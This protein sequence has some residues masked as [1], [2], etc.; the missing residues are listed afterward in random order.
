MKL[1]LRFHLLLDMRT[2][3][4]INSSARTARSHTR[5][6][7]N[8]FV[9]EW[10]CLRPEDLV[11]SREIGTEPPS[12]VSE[13]WIASAFTPPQDRTP[14]MREALR[15]SDTLVDELV[16][17]DLIVLGAPMYNFGMPAQLKA[18]VDQ[19]IRVG[20]TFALDVSDEKQ[21][22]RPLLIGK[23]MLVITATGD[24]GYQ[25]GGPLE[26]LNHLDPHLRTA[27][28]SIGIT[29]IDFAGVSYDEFLD[30]RIKRSLAAAEAKVRQIAH[31]LAHAWGG[32]VPP[33]LRPIPLFP[34]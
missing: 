32:E 15:L 26:H 3:L 33:F 23:R 5:Y 12:P 19:I 17:A 31:Q 34:A 1:H 11:I 25:T 13:A 24:A 14:A 6:L 29:E 4:H 7:S 2:V 28:G 8:L 27:F 22:Y 16:Q 18:Y 10:R 30:D 9:R 21:P 20:R